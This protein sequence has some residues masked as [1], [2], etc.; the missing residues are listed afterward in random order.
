MDC[1]VHQNKLPGMDMIYSFQ[2][3]RNTDRVGVEHRG[4]HY[5]IGINEEMKEAILKKD[6]QLHIL[7]KTICL[8]SRKEIP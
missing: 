1:L 3:V 8:P 6:S 5:H 4:H 2:E 7:R